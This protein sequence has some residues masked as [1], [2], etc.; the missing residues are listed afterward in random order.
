M[1]DYSKEGGFLLK[2]NFFNAFIYFFILTFIVMRN[3]ITVVNH[4]VLMMIRLQSR[5]S[6]TAPK[7]AVTGDLHQFDKMTYGWFDG[8]QWIKAFMDS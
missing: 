6:R 1:N 8:T 4:T 2:L 3:S 5:K 7:E